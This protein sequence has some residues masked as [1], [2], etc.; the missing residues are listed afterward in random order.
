M[1]NSI[2]QPLKDHDL[3]YIDS[4]K[5]SVQAS[6][7]DR[8][9]REDAYEEIITILTRALALLRWQMQDI[10]RQIENDRNRPFEN[11]VNKEDLLKFSE[12]FK[13]FYRIYIRVAFFM[14]DVFT[15]RKY[16]LL[17]K[18][19]WD[20]R[21][22]ARR[23]YTLM[24]ETNF[25]QKD[26]L[27]ANVNQPFK[28]TQRYGD[29]TAFLEVVKCRK[30][31]VDFLEEHKASVQ[32]VRL[33]NEAHKSAD[34]DKQFAAIEELSVKEAMLLIEKYEDLLMDYFGSL[35][36]YHKSLDEYNKRAREV[37]LGPAT[38]VGAFW[39]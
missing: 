21:F 22:F 16:M 33:W 13:E 26:S 25:A 2:P 36:M 32:Q 38:L 11:I 14:V 20:F 17:A 1:D 35:A 39:G 19:D 34:T 31:L 3:N 24:Y 23:I 8:Q 15:A 29:E 30:A 27:L 18:T 9:T 10:E 37:R 5:D 28:N 12:A 6:A 7:E 4:I